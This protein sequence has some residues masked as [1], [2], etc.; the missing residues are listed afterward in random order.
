MILF[1]L[2][3]DFSKKNQMFRRGLALAIRYKRPIAVVTASTGLLLG[4]HHVQNKKPLVSS[5]ILDD[6]VRLKSV[7]A[8]A[9]L[10]VDV[11]KIDDSEWKH[12]LMT[13]EIISH[14][15]QLFPQQPKHYNSELRKFQESVSGSYHPS[16]VQFMRE[17]DVKL[18]GSFVVAKA[19]GK[20][21]A[22]FEPN[23][24]DF[25]VGSQR[26]AEKMAIYMESRFGYTCSVKLDG[27]DHAHVWHLTPPPHHKTR[28]PIDL[29]LPHAD[30]TKSYA[31]LTFLQ[32]EFDGW[33]TRTY[34]LQKRGWYQPRKPV[35][36]TDEVEH[37]Q[38]ISK[39]I[40]RGFAITLTQSQ[41]EAFHALEKSGRVGTSKTVTSGCNRDSN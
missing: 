12:L 25:L 32:N 7:Y 8:K 15:E 11:L 17:H 38:L 1:S 20:E 19:L 18:V 37:Y 35:D 28:P 23:D 9:F 33:K 4:I 22:G 26:D 29:I 30:N 2:S 34:G 10:P 36:S 21:A 41:L 3:I 40:N 5:N 24:L 16:L 31:I 6:P 27:Y 14:L 39:W 13:H